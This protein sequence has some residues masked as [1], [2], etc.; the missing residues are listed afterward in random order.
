VKVITKNDNKYPQ[1]LKQIKNAPSLLYVEGNYELLNNNVAIT[2]IGSRNMSSYGKSVTENIVRDLVKNDICIVSGLAVG[3]DSVAHKICLN[4]N[5]KTIAVLGSG[6]NKVFPI[7][8]IGLYNSI[9]ANGGC[10]I[11]EYS[12]DTVANKAYFPQRNRIVSGLSVATL[13]IEATYRSG[14]SITAT[15][16]FNQGR[17]VYCIPNCIGNKNSSGTLNLLKK[18]AKVITSAEEILL[19]LGL[20]NNTKTENIEDI[21]E[22]NKLLELEKYKLEGLDSETIEIYDCIKIN[23]VVNSEVIAKIMKKPIQ[24]IN[25]HLSILEIKGLIEENG[26]MNFSIID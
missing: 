8:N 21:L 17:K 16:A 10:V 1:M 14:T 26:F 7:E 3:I 9:I 4:N 20:I 22:E 12:P 2:V 15:Y 6:L 18:G 13:V 11:T 5:G 23:G 24:E 25:I 19:D